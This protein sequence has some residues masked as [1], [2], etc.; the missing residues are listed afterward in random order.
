M[1]IA[2]N[3]PRNKIFVFY[4]CTPWCNFLYFSPFWCK[5][6]PLL[7]GKEVFITENLTK[8]QKKFLCHYL[9]SKNI[10]EAAAACGIPAAS[11]YEE[12]IKIMRHPQAWDFISNLEVMMK[13]F[14]GDC[15][16]ES[17]DRLINGRVN[18][19]AIFA[20]TNPEE[21]SDEDIRRLD[22]YNVTELKIGKGVCEMKFTDRLKAIEKLNEIRSGRAV[23]GMAQSFFDAIDGAAEKNSG[24]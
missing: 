22:L 19:A 10:S 17:L 8:K 20:R 23:D 1:G 3:V 6:T 13:K 2:T 4:S 9:K 16:E 5:A 11:A 12:G 7:Y 21:L 15:V 14:G 24:E 18:D